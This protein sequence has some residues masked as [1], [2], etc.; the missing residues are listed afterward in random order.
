MRTTLRG[1]GPA[2]PAEGAPNASTAS[3]AEESFGTR[4]RPVEYTGGCVVKPRRRAPAPL[5]RGSGVVEWPV[6]ATTL[7]IGLALAAPSAA[8]RPNVLLVTV[9]T[10]RP[11]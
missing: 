6:I 2:R 10:L 3:A 5:V 1:A 7:A 9:D 4:A 11:D 8:G